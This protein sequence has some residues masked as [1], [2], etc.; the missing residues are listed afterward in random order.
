M[1]PIQKLMSLGQSL[2][3]D[4]ILRSLLENGTLSG[5]INNGELRGITSNPS[6]FNEAI[7]KSN[8]Y[9]S[10]LKSLSRTGLNAQQIMDRL[11][12]QDIQMAADLFRPLYDSANGGDGFV[13]LEVNPTLANDTETTVKEARRLWQLVDRPNV[14]IKIPAT[15]HGIPAIRR[16]IAAGININITLI[17]SLDR[18][19]EVIHAYL[20]GITERIKK[21][22]PVHQIA[23][24]ASFFVSRVD[25]KVDR[26]LTEI[27][28]KSGQQA[29]MANRLLGKA[30][31]A[32]AKLAYQMYL[33]IFEGQAFKNIEKQGAVHQRP[34]WASTS[35]KNPAYSDVK[36]IEEL[37]GPNTVNT[38]PQK[39]LDAYRDHGN[40]KVR[41][42]ENLEEA[43]LVSKDLEQ[44]GIY[45]EQVT[46]ELEVEG[47]SAFSDSFT[48]LHQTIDERRK[49]FV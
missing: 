41:I 49:A 35:T 26:Q 21:G 22:Q 8:D 19:D 43:R 34:L 12:V 39:T 14:M 2:W 3:Y 31:V 10:A 16:S 42:T 5:L 45:M 18:Y 48:A 4:N 7:S 38:V 15:E 32:N 27:I 36:Y 23:S 24:V 29:E 25:T 33:N 6:I 44:L 46:R 47:V 11:M 13:S 20:D 28:Q 9:D 40:P 1:N 17:F 30:A 37:I